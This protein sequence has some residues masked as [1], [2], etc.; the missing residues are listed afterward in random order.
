M[1]GF[2]FCTPSKEKQGWAGD[3]AHVGADTRVIAHKG[4]KVENNH[5]DGSARPSSFSVDPA[6]ARLPGIHPAAERGAAQ[7]AGAAAEGSLQPPRLH[8]ATSVSPGRAGQWGLLPGQRENKP[9][10]SPEAGNLWFSTSTQRSKSAAAGLDQPWGSF[11]ST[12]SWCLPGKLLPAMLLPVKLLPA[13]LLAMLLPA[14]LLPAKL[15]P[16]KIPACKAPACD[17]PACNAPACDAPACKPP[18][19]EA[20]AFKTPACKTA[21]EAP[22]CE[23]PA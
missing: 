17:A 23:A 19:C 20:P 11:P 6:A 13:K 21:C 4:L 8:K 7:P 12:A 3:A 2:C 5:F 10:G 15:L 22:A 16:G 14:M 1:L 9:Q 18:A